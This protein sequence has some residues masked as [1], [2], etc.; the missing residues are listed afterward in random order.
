MGSLIAT[1]L[2]VVVLAFF[3]VRRGQ[4]GSIARHRQGRWFLWL[5]AALLGVYAAFWFFF[6][7]GEIVGGDWSGAVHLGPGVL[8]LVLLFLTLRRPVEAA[9]V[10]PALGMLVA[11]YIILSSHGNL[12]ATLQAALI[13]G[14]AYLLA[15]SLIVTAVVWVRLDSGE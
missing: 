1:L 5:G 6:G 12:R 4:D 15:G 7:L 13:G 8:T 2:A 9:W 3:A 10:L 11:V 14:A